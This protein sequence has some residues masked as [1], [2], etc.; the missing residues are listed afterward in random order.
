MNSNKPTARQ[1]LCLEVIQ[2]Y[3]AK[4]GYPPSVR[5]IMDA[6]DIASTEGVSTH[7]RALCRKGY[8]ERDKGVSR[9]I[10][11]IKQEELNQYE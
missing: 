3:I 8:I 10:R 6:M 5:D 7:L 4:Y 2:E 11:V 9:G 1:S